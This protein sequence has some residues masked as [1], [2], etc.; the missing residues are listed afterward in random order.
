MYCAISGV[1]PEE[2]IVS[3][4]SGHIFEKRLILKHIQATGKCPV[5]GEELGEDDLIQ[6]QENLIVHPRTSNATSIPSLLSLFQSEW[7]AVVEELYEVK[8]QLHETRQQ[9]AQALYENDAAKRV[10]ARILKE[11][12]EA[13]RIATNESIQVATPL[14]GSLD[15]DH[16]KPQPMEQVV[17]TANQADVNSD[18]ANSSTLLPVEVL[19]RI[20]TKSKELVSYRKTR[21]LSAPVSR[22]DI[23]AW[24]EQLSIKVHQGK[25]K[26][27]KVMTFHPKDKSLLFTGGKD[28]TAKLVSLENNKTLSSASAH[29]APITDLV[30]HGDKNLLL[31][32]SMDNTVKLWSW[33]ATETKKMKVLSTFDTHEAAV[34]G[35]SLHPYMTYFVTA[36]EDCTWA[37][38]DLESGTCL[39]RSSKMSSPFSCVG[40]HP[41]G[42]ILS[43]GCKNGSLN[44]W[45]IRAMKVELALQENNDSSQDTVVSLSFSENGYYMASLDERQLYLWDLRKPNEAIH[46]WSLSDNNNGRGCSFDSSGIY[47]GIVA[48]CQMQ[49]FEA[50]K[51]V[52]CVNISCSSDQ[53]PCH[54]DLA[55]IAFAPETSCC[56]IGDVEGM[57]HLFDKTRPTET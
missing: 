28:K 20:S 31:T 35:V 18:Q 5:T 14:N 41:D 15:G 33:E 47:L 30:V 19:D 36:S 23:A 53:L 45:D 42:L 29:K 26:E 54:S 43:T 13:L 46:Q 51:A 34:T 27:V 56:V 48:T 57:I 6:V 16:R 9:L 7:D 25:E 40:I 39:V 49:I 50:K 22:D 38:H 52:E 10:I 32:S 3:K 17:E 4:K 12:D 11:R 1:T 8:K 37:F 21:K 44:I 55:S 2:P 24:R